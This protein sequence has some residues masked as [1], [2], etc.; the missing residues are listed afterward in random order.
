MSIIEKLKTVKTMPELDALRTETA[1]AMMLDGTSETF[2]KVQ[3]ALIKAKNRLRRVPLKDR[4][5]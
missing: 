1:E 4:T 2:K 5:W 3:T